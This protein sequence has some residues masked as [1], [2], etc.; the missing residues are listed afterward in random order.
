MFQLLSRFLS[1]S[2]RHSS[3]QVSDWQM[4]QRF[5]SY[6]IPH[7]KWVFLGLAAIPFSVGATLLLPWLIISIVDDHL[8]LGDFAGLVQIVIWMG[9]VIIAGYFTDSIYT[10]SLQK[11]GQLAIYEMRKDLYAH[12][13][14][15]PRSFFDQYPVGVILTRITS[16]LEALGDSLAVGV[17]SIFTDLLK[18]TALLCMLLYFSWELTL[19]VLFI[20]PPIYFISNFLRNYLRYYYDMTRESLAAATGFLQECLNGVQTVQLYAAEKRV[21]YE[22]EQKTQKIFLCAVTIQFF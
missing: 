10:F 3:H 21:Q 11:S 6:W 14:S 13:L 16:D 5:L 4:M 8:I 17:L 9:I 18:T 20:L 22:Y 19:V 15:L 12:V 2:P 1:V 7:R